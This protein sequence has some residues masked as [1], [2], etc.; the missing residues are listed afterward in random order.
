MLLV[1]LDRSSA[2]PAYLQIRDRIAGLVEDGSLCPGDRL[3]PSRHLAGSVG[4]HRSTVVRAYDELRA[5]GYLDSRSGSYTTVR[6]RARP[7]ATAVRP[8]DTRDLIEWRSSR[9]GSSPRLDDRPSA[10]ATA[11]GGAVDFERLAAD[12]SLAPAAD[13][14]R[15]LRAA[16]SADAPA[17]VDYA[18]P[19]G[20]PP[21]RQTL[22]R[23]LRAHGMA[24]SPDEIVI[25]HGAQQA[26]DLILRMLAGPGDRVAVEAPTYGMLHPLLRLHGVEPVEVPMRDDGMD[27]DAL[28]SLL[29]RSRVRFVYT[30]PNFHNPTGITTDQAHRERL[31]ALC[32]AHR[33]PLVE[34]GFEEEMK[35]LGRAVLP[36]KSMDAHGVVLYVGTLSKVVFPGLRLGWIAGPSEAARRLEELQHATC[37]AANTLSQAAADRFIRSGDLELYLRRAHRIFRRR[38]AALLDGLERHLPP[39]TA[40]TRPVGG[41]TL[42]LTLA[43]PA[44]DEPAL[45]RELAGAGVLVAPGRWYYAAPPPTAHLR[46]SIA[47]VDATRIDDGCRRLGEVLRMTGC[48]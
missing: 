43:R 19:A 45:V 33:T 39:G 31:L 7:P 46:L 30:M 21:L 38:M 29:D 13:L 22:S 28:A 37:L 3:P 34:D 40:W 24:V 6:R 2:T 35:Y 36:V 8:R 42:W 44:A 9:S 17:S 25:T 10:A 27:L 5:L 20:W 4:V 23:R 14:R 15:C 47:C 18:S 26:L 11:Q 16:L 12:P 48:R 41:Y 32:E 1:E